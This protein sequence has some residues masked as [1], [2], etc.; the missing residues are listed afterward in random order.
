MPPSAKF[1]LPP[2]TA[3]FS[4]STTF[5]PASCALRAAVMPAPPAPTTMMSNDPSSFTVASPEP[6]CGEHPTSPTPGSIAAR[7]RPIEP[8]K[9]VR[10]LM[11][12]LA[13]WFS[14]LS[15]R[16]FMVV[17]L[18]VSMR[19]R[20]VFVGSTVRRKDVRAE[21]SYRVACTPESGDLCIF[22]DQWR[23]LTPAEKGFSFC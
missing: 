11:A 15:M 3:I 13:R 10:R 22:A 16:S 12:A 2:T 17:L 14:L 18:L 4:S 5:A 19:L 7:P 21:A 6:A 8:A 9:N 1:V 20:G 23:G